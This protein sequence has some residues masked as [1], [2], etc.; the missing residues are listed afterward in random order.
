MQGILEILKGFQP[1]TLEEIGKVKLMDRR[2]TKFLFPAIRLPEILE[3]LTTLYRV[4]EVRESRAPRYE[5]VYYD[6]PELF[7]YYQHHSKHLNRYKVRTRKY[8]D[9]DD[10]F[11]E[12]KF[13]NNHGRTIKE[14]I[15]IDDAL[16]GIDEQVAAFILKKSTLDASLLEPKL[17]IQYCRIT[18]VNPEETERVTI[19]CNLQYSNGTHQKSYQE[20][21]IAE[22][23]QDH[24]SCSSFERLMRKKKIREFSISKYCLGIV[25][26]YGHVRHNHFKP[27]IKQLNKLVYDSHGNSEHGPGAARV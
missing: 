17:R 19:D 8:L 5:T 10:S 3:E 22:V 6:T 23:K 24:H 1:I 15:K 26:L 4:L 9:T 16:N 2:D 18:L 21:I 27:K 14:R 7:S 20:V 11:F 25:S 13:K 12:I